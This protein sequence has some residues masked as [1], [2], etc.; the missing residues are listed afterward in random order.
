MTQLHPHEYS[1]ESMP[2]GSTAVKLL[3]GLLHVCAVLYVETI[4]ILGLAIYCLLVE[5]ASVYHFILPEQYVIRFRH[6][7]GCR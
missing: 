5:I 4:Q 6:P 3:N 1:I 2:I 7:P